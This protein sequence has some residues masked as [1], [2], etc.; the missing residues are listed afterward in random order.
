MKTTKG[1]VHKIRQ[2]FMPWLSIALTTSLVALAL[3]LSSLWIQQRDQYQQLSNAQRYASEL[4]NSILRQEFLLHTD[5]L[6][7]LSDNTAIT[8]VARTLL[9]AY[10]NYL[11]IELRGPSNFQSLSG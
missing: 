4:T 10:P 6:Q 5:L 9:N 8:V 1:A 2:R 7:M 3:V 11:R